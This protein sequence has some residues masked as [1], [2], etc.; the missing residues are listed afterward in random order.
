MATFFNQATLTYN[1]TAINSNV[2]TG[3]LVNALSVTKTAVIDTYTRDSEVT[4]VLSVVNTGDAPIAGVTVTDDLGQYDFNGTALVPLTYVDG[5]A[6]LFINGVLQADPAVEA[7]P[8][9]VIGGL[10]VPASGVATLIYVARV[11]EFAP[12]DA[13]STVVNRAVVTG[14]CTDVEATAT[15]TVRSEADL[16]ITKSL[17]PAT[18]TCGGRLTY[19]FVIA[20]TGNEAVVATDDA[21]ITDTF[22]PALSDIAVTFNGTV[23]TAGVDYTYDETTG[24]FATLPGRITVP[25]ATFTQNDDGTWTIQPGVSTLTVSGTV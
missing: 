10:T 13:G 5:S 19:T 16:A 8:P 1:G 14:S 4:Y 17:T 24:E 21:V 7:G 20:N 9:L 6:T 22:D 25:A 11:N 12:L 15:I 18:V 3:E 23:L 2:T